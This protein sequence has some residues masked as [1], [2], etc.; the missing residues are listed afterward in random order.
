[1]LYFL[2][3]L[4]IIHL[5]LTI[6]CIRGMYQ[7]FF[8]KD[9]YIH[10]NYTGETSK[11]G[12]GIRLFIDMLF[13]SDTPENWLRAQRIHFILVLTYLVVINIFFTYVL[14]VTL[15]PDRFGVTP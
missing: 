4:L 10:K 11:A 13:P 2:S 7:A 12:T 3:F 6:G 5:L 14:L 1:M 8:R 15:V 9:Q